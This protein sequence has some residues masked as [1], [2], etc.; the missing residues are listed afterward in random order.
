MRNSLSP[1]AIWWALLLSPVMLAPVARAMVASGPPTPQPMSA[2]CMP[3][4]RLSRR[5]TPSS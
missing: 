5:P 3:G 4:R 1:L 2:T